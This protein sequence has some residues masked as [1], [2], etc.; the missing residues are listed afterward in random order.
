MVATRQLQTSKIQSLNELLIVLPAVTYFHM[1]IILHVYI[2]YTT[3]S[4]SLQLL[5]LPS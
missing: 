5:Q 1:A 4:F 2:H 3:V